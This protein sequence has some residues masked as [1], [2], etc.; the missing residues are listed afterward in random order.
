MGKC[1]LTDLPSTRKHRGLYICDQYFE[2]AR[3]LAEKYAISEFEA[4]DVLL[5]YK[6]GVAILGEEKL[7]PETIREEGKWKNKLKKMLKK[8]K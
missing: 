5:S 1:T 2:G 4:M 7:E 6:S 3:K 8:S